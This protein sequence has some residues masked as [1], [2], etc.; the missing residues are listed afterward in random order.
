MS[1]HPE[2]PTD[3]QVLAALQGTDEGLTPTELIQAL[4]DDGHTE[5]NIIRA[6]QRVFDRNK[7]SLSEDAKLVPTPV[8]EP[9][10]A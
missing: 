3:E 10:F 8:G 4:R 7:V 2:I 1:D 6:I 9:A 5:E